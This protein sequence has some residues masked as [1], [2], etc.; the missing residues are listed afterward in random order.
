MDRKPVSS[1]EHICELCSQIVRT[2]VAK[3]ANPLVGLHLVLKDG[4]IEFKRYFHG[5]GKSF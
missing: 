2:M 1:T 4:K 5:H 3:V